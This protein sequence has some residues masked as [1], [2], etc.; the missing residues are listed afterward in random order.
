LLL[1]AGIHA[2]LRGASLGVGGA[3]ARVVAGVIAGLRRGECEGPAPDRECDG[4]Q[5]EDAE[6]APVEGAPEL[7]LE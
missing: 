6:D 4:Q 1:H 3:D 7:A 5:R 2:R